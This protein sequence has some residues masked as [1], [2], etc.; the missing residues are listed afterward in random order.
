VGRQLAAQANEIGGRLLA[1]LL[2]ARIDGK[3]PVEYITDAA[4]QEH[5]RVTAKG[6]LRRNLTLLE[7]L[8]EISPALADWAEKKVEST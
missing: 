1:A 3:S 5:I 8:D 6:L 7:T 4:L 2:L